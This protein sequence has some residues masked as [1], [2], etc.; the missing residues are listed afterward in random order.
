MPSFSYSQSARQYRDNRSGKFLSTEQA[1]GLIEKQIG[2]I[3]KDIGT[4]GD[5]LAGD[6]IS[7]AT[8]EQE[9]AAALKTLHIQS[10]VLGRGGMRQM[11]DND[12]RNI[13]D[14]LRFQFQK[15]RGFSQDIVNEGMSEAQFKARLE[16]YTNAARS[17]YENGRRAAHGEGWLERRLLGGTNNC[18][19]C[20]T[21][22]AR[23]WLA[24]GT[25]PG[26]GDACDCM[27]RCRCSFE[28]SSTNP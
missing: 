21:Y 25:L 8:W 13:S 11:G 22:S 15:L 28:F 2:L 24:V 9:T 16:L 12:Y 7:V 23:G 17:S 4:I 1:K 10:Y 3:S 26:I 6:L 20:L 27:S 14:K 5:L 19:P 18:D